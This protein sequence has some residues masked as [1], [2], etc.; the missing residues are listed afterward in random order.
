MILFKLL[1][2]FA[3]TGRCLRAGRLP[4]LLWILKSSVLPTQV[5]FGLFP[6]VM[7]FI[8]A[9]LNCFLLDWS[10]YLVALLIK[11]SR[12]HCA[13]S[14]LIKIDLCKA[15]D[16]INWQFLKEMM[17]A[18]NFPNHFVHIVMTCVTST[19]YALMLNGSPP[20][21]F[22]LSEVLDKGPLSPP[23]FS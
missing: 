10:R 6:I 13:P 14:C 21:P 19:R 18:L 1:I 9:S 15:Y 3:V 11:Y 17:I 12:K 4:Q 2:S 16:I 20:L 22:R 23:Y 8:N 5:I 7:L